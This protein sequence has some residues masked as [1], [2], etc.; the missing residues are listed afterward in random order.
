MV[1]ESPRFRKRYQSDGGT[2]NVDK[3]S[4][5]GKQSV[6]AVALRSRVQQFENFDINLPGN[7]RTSCYGS[8]DSVSCSSWI[9]PPTS[10]PINVVSTEVDQQVTVG[11]YTYTLTCRAHWVGSACMPL[12]DGDQFLA[13][14]DGTT[15]RIEG[16]RNGNMGKQIRPKFRILDIR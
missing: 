7:V 3:P 4:S 12:R 2:R 6:V 5:P 10:I 13:E 16:R 14:I 9:T 1:D 15:M 8:W 11:D